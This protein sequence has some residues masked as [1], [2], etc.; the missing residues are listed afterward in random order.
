MF[1][2]QTEPKLSR[3]DSCFSSRIIKYRNINTTWLCSRLYLTL[4]EI[5]FFWF[6][7][8]FSSH[9]NSVLH[10]LSI[11]NSNSDGNVDWN[12]MLTSGICFNHQI[13][14]QKYIRVN[15][16]S[17]ASTSELIPETVNQTSGITMTTVIRIITKV[18]EAVST[19]PCF[20]MRNYFQILLWMWCEQADC[21]PGQAGHI[22]SILSPRTTA[23]CTANFP[24]KYKFNLSLSLSFSLSLFQIS[25][26]NS[27]HWSWRFYIMIY[28]K[29]HLVYLAFRKVQ[30]P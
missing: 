15:S 13:I 2:I 29:R 10:Q 24:Y 6:F 3:E 30:F 12:P 16:S 9:Y 17:Q 27:F 23:L 26:T 18:P 1:P 28:N 4:W 21:Q 22:S 7:Y 5:K 14:S 25:L 20:V 11:Y 8:L 19:I